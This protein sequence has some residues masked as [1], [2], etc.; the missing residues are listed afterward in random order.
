MA[1]SA[2][3]AKP[4]FSYI[5]GPPA[6]GWHCPQGTGPSHTPLIKKLSPQ[7]R[8]QARLME[9]SLNRGCLL[10]CEPSLCQVEQSKT[11]HTQFSFELPDLKH[12]PKAFEELQTDQCSI[13][14][15]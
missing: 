10:L 15:N 12:I 3:L 13:L 9:A 6:L 4:V 7:A 8:L 5:R 14:A 1:C 11:K 2:L